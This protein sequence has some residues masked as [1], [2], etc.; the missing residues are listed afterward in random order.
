MIA[1][2]AALA[3][4]A[5]DAVLASG[6]YRYAIYSD[7]EPAGISTIVVTRKNGSIQIAERTSLQGEPIN[8]TRTIDPSTFATLDYVVGTQ[9]NEESIEISG[10]SATHHAGGKATTLS[11]ATDGPSIVFDY[12]VGEYVALPA[13]IR[14]ETTPAFNAYCVC[15]AGFEVKPSALVP[16]TAARPTGIPSGDAAVAFVL[17]DETATLWYDPVTL[18]TAELDVPGPKFKIV[19]EQ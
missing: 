13:M 19:L 11:Q 14:A 10:K 2:A 7:N 8:T 12:L 6:T 1:L 4:P 18:V 3:P 16:A 9:G 5:A 15:I 17:D